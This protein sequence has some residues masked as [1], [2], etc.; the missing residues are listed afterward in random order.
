M[1]LLTKEL[2]EKLVANFNSNNTYDRS[3]NMDFQPVVKFFYPAGAATW[4]FTEFDEENELLFGLC[5]LGHGFPEIGYASLREIQEFRGWF[6]LGI[7]RDKGWKADKTLAEYAE[8]A[9]YAGRIV[10]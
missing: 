5:D 8:I 9:H 2:R 3:I 10:A 6:G 4:L 1:K 7:E